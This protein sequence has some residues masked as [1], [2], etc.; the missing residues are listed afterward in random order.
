M[1]CCHK[2]GDHLRHRHP[3]GGGALHHGGGRLPGADGCCLKGQGV[4]RETLNK[5]AVEIGLDK[6]IK[7]STRSSC[8]NSYMYGNAFKAFIGAIYLD[9]GYERCKLFMEQRIINRYIDLDKIDVYKRQPQIET[10]GILTRDAKCILAESIESITSRWL[11]RFSSV[12][13][14]SQICV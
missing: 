3:G 12:R 10:T 8:H 4:Q 9:Q 11:I 1:N 6:L 7:Y 13:I 14:F 5:L 2:I